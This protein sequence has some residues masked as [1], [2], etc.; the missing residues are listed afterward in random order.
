MTAGLCR[1][2]RHGV[3]RIPALAALLLVAG[4]ACGGEPAAPRELPPDVQADV[5]AIAGHLAQVSDTSPAL[6]C[7]KAVENAR[8][9]VETM[10]EVGEKNLRAGYMSQPAYDAAIPALKRLLAALAAED[11]A[12]ATGARRDFYQCMSSDYNH[13]YACGKAHPFDP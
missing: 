9:G 7:D 1:S 5:T 3:L 12:A 8:W 11:C 2:H 4:M 13:V 10:L 6:S